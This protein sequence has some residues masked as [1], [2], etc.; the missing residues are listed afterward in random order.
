[1]ITAAFAVKNILVFDYKCV[2][3][4]GK[5]RLTKYEFAQAADDVDYALEELD[6]DV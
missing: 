3:G 1:M 4:V 6:K 2:W 5:N